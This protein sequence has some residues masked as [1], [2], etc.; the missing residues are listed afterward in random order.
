M[1]WPVKMT[2]ND[3][4]ATGPLEPVVDVVWCC[5]WDPPCNESNG[6]LD[7]RLPEDNVSK[8][9][10]KSGFNRIWCVSMYLYLAVRLFIYLSS[11]LTNLSPSLSLSRSLSLFHRASVYTIIYVISI[12]SAST[13]VF[14]STSSTSSHL[15][16]QISIYQSTHQSIHQ[17]INQ[18]VYDCIRCIR[19]YIYI[20]AHTHTAQHAL[21][22]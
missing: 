19:M 17:S 1:S 12:F 4:W 15:V 10:I 13:S 22:C 16:Y 8:Q 5:P 18:P 21:V 6:S 9:W 7:R 3:H 2:I 20:R 14:H 11:S